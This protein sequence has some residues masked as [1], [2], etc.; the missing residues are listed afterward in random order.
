VSNKTRVAKEE[1]IDLLNELKKK[2]EL[3]R[4]VINEGRVSSLE[5]LIN[6][7]Q[8]LID[9]IDKLSNSFK[10]QP[11]FSEV[12]SKILK[13]IKEIDE[14]NSGLLEEK[15]SQ[16]KKIIN[17]LQKGKKATANYHKKLS[18]SGGVFLD[19]RH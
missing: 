8:E 19:K 16:L 4:K 7:K 14:K 3:Q 12:E 11:G 15:V 1:R 9:K 6:K 5:R 10:Q 2:S 13:E 18:P 17:R